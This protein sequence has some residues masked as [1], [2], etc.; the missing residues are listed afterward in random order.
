LK[1]FSFA[2][3]AFVSTFEPKDIGHALSDHNWVNSMHEELENFE[4]NQV[5]E[6]VALPQGVSQLGQMGVEEQRGR[7]R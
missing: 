6:L 7:E 4:W 3:A 2:Y 1:Q 5:W